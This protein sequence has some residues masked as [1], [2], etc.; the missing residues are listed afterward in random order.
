[1]SVFL[2]TAVSCAIWMII[3][4]LFWRPWSVRESLDSNSSTESLDLSDVTALIPAR[5]EA[6][7]IVTTLQSLANQG[8]GLNI[9]LVDDQSTDNIA[10]LA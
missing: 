8:Q 9:I 1:M 3:L 5:N 7:T 4:I 10:E 6:A 2:L